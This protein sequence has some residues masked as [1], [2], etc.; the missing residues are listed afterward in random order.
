[1]SFYK[2]TVRDIDLKDKRVLLRV[3]YNVPI[4]DGKVTSDYRIE[5]SLPTLKY[6]IEQGC[7]IVII[8]HLGRPDGMRNE[9]FS[10]KPAAEV[11][12][13]LI[14]KKV[15]FQEDCLGPEVEQAVTQ[16]KSGELLML[17]NVRF[18]PEEEADDT[19]FA[20]KLA[21]YGNVFVQDAFGVVHRAHASTHAVTKHLPSVAGLL[22]EKEVTTI[23][24]LLQNPKHPMV[25][26]LGGA[27]IS[28]KIRVIER[29]MKLADVISI[30]GAMA[31]TFLL[32]EGIDV[33]DSLVEKDDVKLAKEIMEKA[34]EEAKKRPF[35][36]YL[37]QDGVVATSLENP[38]E[39]RIVEW[40]SCVISDIE[41]YPKQ[42]GKF[43]SQ[44]KSGEMI[45]DIGPISGSF[46]AGTLQLA[47][48]VIWNGTLGV[49]EVKGLNSDPVGPFAH[50]TEL[51]VESMMG[52]Y[53]NRP[54]SF[55]GGG[56]T[57][58]YVENRGLTKAFNH[59]STGGGASLELLEGKKL[60]GV[61]ALKDKK[62]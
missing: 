54:Y 48:S 55:V 29:F 3:D 47:S 7:K 5:Q 8:S 10:L 27:K 52:P 43:A 50:G 16:L 1:V 19:E 20:K 6:L 62:T 42:P 39:T 23:V 14:D 26:I 34:R 15:S 12:E 49:A 44:L 18:Y 31:N 4:K 56:D 36:F 53:G 11:L 35:V 40:D 51:V 30:G 21:T 41:A 28:E 24:E 9:R 58:S 38:K 61:D 33:G 45:L 22:L 2:Q 32:A 37:P 46:I 17:E 25:A 57:V 59:V 60:P 13:K